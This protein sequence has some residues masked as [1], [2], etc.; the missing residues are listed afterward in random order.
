MSKSSVTLPEDMSILAGELGSSNCTLE[1][2]RPLVPFSE[3]A[4][5][6]LGEVSAA[7]LRDREAR[8]FS[9]VLAFAY[10]CR[11][12]NVL[13]KREAFL[14]STGDECRLGRGIAF[15]IAPSNVPVN[16]AFSF[17]FSLLAGNANIVRVPSKPFGQV[18]AI[19]RVM[20]DVMESYD[21]IRESNVFVRYPSSSSATAE[22]CAVADVR[23]IWGGDAT[24]ANIR[25]MASPPR[26]ID[27]CFSDRYSFGV[28]DGAA[29]M[30][31]SQDAM[32]QLARDFYND[33][34]L[35][36]QNAC[37]SPMLIAWLH[38][39]NEAS[40]RFWSFVSA[41]AH[42]HYVLQ[43]AVSVDKYV[44]ACED[45]LDGIAR[46]PIDSY[47]G[48]LTVRDA[49][50]YALGS[51][52]DDVDL[53]SLREKGGYFYEVSIRSVA[54][55]LT[56][57]DERFQTVV[58]FG[59][60]SLGESIA[61][62]IVNSRVRGIDRIVPFGRAMDIDIIWDGFDLPMALSRIIDHS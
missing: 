44:K 36:D 32:E 30:G 59:D 38:G 60:E 4:C 27:I 11:R 18:E 12:S 47:D 50:D 25:A 2:A 21:I 37:S 26:C 43:D 53:V 23:M 22:L 5:A 31:A 15:H 24:V 14:A 62:D 34:Y 42:E 9:D 56:H 13:A 55:I 19:C 57:V 8:R 1:A 35:M 54:D 33:T 16:F 61:Q 7:L 39:S 46:E 20:S 52:P 40:D 17:V 58:Y 45:A 49:T 51:H 3:E 48:F 10:W 28:I 41:Y 6:F 29:I